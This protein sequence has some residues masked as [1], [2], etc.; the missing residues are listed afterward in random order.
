MGMSNSNTESPEG[1]RQTVQEEVARQQAAQQKAQARRE[2][3]AQREAAHK[4]A[5]YEQEL[6]NHAERM[7]A[8]RNQEGANAYSRENYTAKHARSGSGHK[9]RNTIIAVIVILVIVI[10]GCGAAFALSV[11]QA[12]DDAET[13]MEDGP[14]LLKQLKAGDKASAQKTAANFAATANDLDNITSNP[15]W[16]VAAALPVYGSD[17]KNVRTIAEVANTLSSKTLIPIVDALPDSGLSELLTKKGINTEIVQ[18]LLS[19]LGN[20]SS[21]ISEC[22]VKV[23][24]MGET[25]LEQIKEPISKM[26]S[27]IESLD[28]VAQQATELSEVLPDM[29]GVN[30]PRKYLIVA[31]NNSELRPTGGLA[32]S[33][34]LLT[35]D[36][37]NMEV[38]D[39][40][41][42]EAVPALSEASRVSITDE[43]SFL[44]GNRIGCDIR[45]SLYVPNFPR[46]AELEKQIWE[47]DG[48]TV[49]EGIIAVDPIFLQSVLALTGTVTTSDGTVVSGDTAAY[50][51]MSGVY[52]R[53]GDDYAREDAFFAEVASHAIQVV[54]EN[55]NKIDVTSLAEMALSLGKQ[56][57]FYVWMVN[58]KEE[59]ILS[60]MGIDGSVSTSE[61]DPVTGV[62][63]GTPI[64]SKINWYLDTDKT[65]SAGRKNAD[66]STSYDVTVTLRNTLSE[67][68]AGDMAWYIISGDSVKRAKSDMVLEV[69]LFA[70]AGGTI[71]NIQANGDFLSDNVFNNS[72]TTTPGPE[73]MSPATYNGQEVR[74]GLTRILGE[75][76]TTITYTVTTSPK[77]SS[78]LQID[79]TPQANQ[80]L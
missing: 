49:I 5:I 61:T 79:M 69:Y 14:K 47:R 74:Y 26:T 22:A 3:Q 40:V 56:R 46:A 7:Q 71:T 18:I 19:T 44:F 37:G 27:L 66:G 62:Y 68:A 48:H 25:H 43:E 24:G 77:A 64:G 42:A 60:K 65:I 58:A 30:S 72:W 28:M 45:D 76:S 78:E 35:I 11:S 21:S 17:V 32:G 38:G 55:T 67:S 63:L 31:C 80:E 75:T 12:R 8:M 50:E 23:E 36:N 51:L 4:Q 70:P 54:F 15:L 59:S 33:F 57:H 13:L 73:P 20:S 53:Y 6:R 2:E 29:L 41:G 9:V 39:F 10:G 16:N 52:L 1:R 34:G